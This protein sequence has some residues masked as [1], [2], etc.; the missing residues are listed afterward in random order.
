[1]SKDYLLRNSLYGFKKEDVIDYIEGIKKESQHHKTLAQKNKDQ[2]EQ[3]ND[4][5]KEL[6]DKIKNLESKEE[7]SSKA[8]LVKINKKSLNNEEVNNLKNEN[9]ILKI[10]VDNLTRECDKFKKNNK[11]FNSLILDAYIH[12]EGIL[13]DAR[14]KA[15]HIADETQNIINITAVDID[16]FSDY[17]NNISTDFSQIVSELTNNIKSLTGNLISATKGIKEQDDK[18]ESEILESFEDLISKYV[19]SDEVVNDEQL[20]FETIN[21]T[22]LLFDDDESFKSLE[23]KYKDNTDVDVVDKNEEL[24]D[25]KE[26]LNNIIDEYVTVDFDNNNVIVDEEDKNVAK[27]KVKIRKNR[28]PEEY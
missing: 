8:Q 22:L 26:K 21:S 28:Y 5:I 18:K 11:Q 7:E 4:K 27:V 6:E 20:S 1:M 24:I 10:Q 13:K 14:D 16:E 15:K 19:D 2:L 3:A 12:S 25:E 23:Q 17:V 9:D